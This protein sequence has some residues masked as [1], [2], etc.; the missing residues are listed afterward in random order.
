MPIGM[1]GYS[2]LHAQDVANCA[3]ICLSDP[4]QHHQKVYRLTGPECLSGNRLIII[5]VG[6]AGKAGLG[7]S[8]PVRFL[9][10]T[11]SEA[12]DAMLRADTPTWVLNGFME[13][14]DLIAKGFFAT[15]SPDV[16][17]L[18]YYKGITVEEFFRRNRDLFNSESEQNRDNSTGTQENAEIILPSKL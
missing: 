8:R 9:N 2:P 3:A 11:K 13:L 7:L 15:V 5:G 17:Q 18:T 4:P 14:F 10:C 16:A 12:K 6:I 1:G